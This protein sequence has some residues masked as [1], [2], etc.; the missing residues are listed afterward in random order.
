MIVNFHDPVH[1]YEEILAGFAKD[2][3]CKVLKL[4]SF[5]AINIRSPCIELELFTLFD[6]M[7][8]KVVVGQKYSCKMSQ[9][10]GMANW[11]KA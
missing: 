6:I 5:L 7:Q 10:L 4:L 9:L 2:L 3:Q 8:I 11:Q 1:N